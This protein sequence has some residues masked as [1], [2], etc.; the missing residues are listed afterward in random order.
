MG[1]VPLHSRDPTLDTVPRKSLGEAAK[2]QFPRKTVVLKNGDR[3]NGA[4]E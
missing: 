4:F 1:E 2:S 3:L